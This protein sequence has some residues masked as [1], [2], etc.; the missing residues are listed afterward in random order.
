MKNNPLKFIRCGLFLAVSIALSSSVVLADWPKNKNVWTCDDTSTFV[1]ADNDNELVLYGG[2][3][4]TVNVYENGKTCFTATRND[5]YEWYWA[6]S[7][8]DNNTTAHA[9][10]ENRKVTE[11]CIFATWGSPAN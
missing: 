2:S 7:G 3:G 11:D 8:W 10:A 9:Y 4:C 6:I 1:E 5:G